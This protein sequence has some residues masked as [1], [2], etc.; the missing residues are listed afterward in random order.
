M[1]PLQ[2]W[3]IQNYVCHVLEDKICQFEMD[4]QSLDSLG[5]GSQNLAL[6]CQRSLL[7]LQFLVSQ[8]HFM[9]SIEQ[10]PVVPH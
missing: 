9:S 7:A 2:Q 5:A 10:V 1:R 3:R 4:G 6:N 8:R